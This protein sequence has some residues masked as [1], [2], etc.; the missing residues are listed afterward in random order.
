MLNYRKIKKGNKHTVEVADGVK[1]KVQGYGTWAGFVRVSI[2]KK[3]WIEIHDVLHVPEMKERLLATSTIRSSGGR[4]VL[5]KTKGMIDL[6]GINVPL[7]TCAESDL[8][9]IKLQ[10]QSWKDR[11][12][13]EREHIGLL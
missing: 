13:K 4:V 5:E 8:D 1:Y 2:R 6:G 10:I 7:E 11:T 9:C 3:I 12:V